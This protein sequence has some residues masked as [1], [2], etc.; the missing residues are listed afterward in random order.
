MQDRYGNAGS[1]AMTGC[2]ARASGF[3]CADHEPGWLE[4]PECQSTPVGPRTII[5]VVDYVRRV[6]DE[7]KPS[8]ASVRGGGRTP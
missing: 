7:A 8:T 5:A 1:C 4:S 6:A 3:F 2:A